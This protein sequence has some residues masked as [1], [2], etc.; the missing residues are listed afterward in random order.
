MRRLRA[1]RPAVPALRDAHPVARR[2]GPSCRGRRTG[3][4][5][6]R[7]RHDAATSA[8]TSVG[9]GWACDVTIRDGE[10]VATT[11]RV[12]P[13]RPAISSASRRRRIDRRTSSAGRSTSCWS[14]SRRRRSSATFDLPGHRP[15]LP[16]VRARDP[17]LTAARII[18]RRCA[19]TT[20]P[21]P[22][23]PSGWTSC[24]RSPNASSDSGS[25]ASAGAR[26]GSTPA[27]GLESPPRHPGLPRRPRAR[28]AWAPPRRPR[29]SSTSAGRPSCRPSASPTPSRS[30]T[31][32]AASRSAT[33]A[34][35]ATSGRGG[36]A[37]RAAG[38]IHGRAD[39]EVGARWLE[40]AWAGA[41]GPGTGPPRAPRD[42]R[43]PGEPRGPDR[44]RR[45]RRL[46]RQHGEP[47]VHVPPRPDRARRHRDLLARP[48]VFRF[49][50]QGQPRGTWS[51]SG[52]R[53]CWID[54]AGP[55][56]RRRMRSAGSG[57]SM[58]ESAI[59]AEGPPAFDERGP[60]DDGPAD[61]AQ[62][63]RIS[64][65]WL[66]LTSID[67][68]VN[69]RRPDAPAVRRPRRARHGGDVTGRRSRRPS[70][71]SRSPSSR[72]SGR[73]ATTRRPAGVGASRSSSPGRCSTRCSWSGSRPPTRS[74]RS[75]RS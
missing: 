47:R 74:S 52:A 20:S 66:G 62:L 63:V 26:P 54:A 6:A 3:A 14:A 56:R 48:I 33:T 11:H 30:T 67:A 60:P 37:Y 53:S 41:D 65:F 45:R 64:L 23:S 42:V 29:R 34:T 27:G 44:R 43:R 46:R 72:P 73:S 71:S 55:C 35:S 8:A 19:S 69:A 5:A 16:G 21:A 36:R 40:D 25:P 59:G 68:V 32:P 4:R 12:A 15:L 18:G 9:S 28:N 24:G 57:G 17:A 50:A 39:T 70:S 38:R 7:R 58:T 61:R 22:P 75:P 1:G 51:E 13:S 10:R 31:R 49:V 2:S